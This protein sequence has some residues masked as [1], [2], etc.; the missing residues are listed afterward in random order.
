M[1]YKWN[2]KLLK[3]NN[4]SKIMLW[5]DQYEIKSYIKKSLILQIWDSVKEYLPKSIIFDLKLKYNIKK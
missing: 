3:I 2:N 5:Y 4:H 1:E